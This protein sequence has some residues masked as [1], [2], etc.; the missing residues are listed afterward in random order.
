MVVEDVR[1]LPQV[2]KR[3]GGECAQPPS[4]PHSPIMNEYHEFLYLL[5]SPPLSIFCEHSVQIP[6]AATNPT[7][8]QNRN[9][10]KLALQCE[11]IH[12]THI[13]LTT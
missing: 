3:H 12:S 11:S 4:H 5:R 1:V 8:H 10:R 9:Q 6:T 13:S 2:S 7:W